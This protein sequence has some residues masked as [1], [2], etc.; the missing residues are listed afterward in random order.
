MTKRYSPPLATKFI[1][2]RISKGILPR[3]RLEQLIEQL[4][5]ATITVLKAPPGFGKSTLA[6]I[7]SDLVQAKGARVAWM[8]LDEADDTPERLLLNV[9]IAIQRGIDGC[10]E[11]T[12][13]KHLSLVPK[14]HM[15]TLL[16]NQVERRDEQCFLF[17]DD[18]HCVFDETLVEAFDG[19]IRHAPENL[20]LVFCGRSDLPTALAAHT[21]GDAL[22]E[23]GAGDLRFTPEE[24]RDLALKAGLDNLGPTELMELHNA[25]EG[26][27]AA[28]RANLLN[29][30]QRPEDSPRL[31][32]NITGLLNELISSLSYDFAEKL[33]RLAAVDKF[34]A[35]LADH[36]T[37][38]NQGFSLIAELERLQLF[39]TGLDRKGEWFSLHPIFREHLRSH[40]QPGELDNIRKRAASWLAEQKLWTDAVR[41][42]LS[43]GDTDSARTWIANCA[44]DV[45]EQG[46][47]MILLDWERELQGRLLQ[48]PPELKLAQA[49]AAA[50]AMR[51]ERA[52]Q[53]LKEAFTELDTMKNNEGKPSLYWECQ[54]VKALT[55]ATEDLFDASGK[56]AAECLPHLVNRHWVYNTLLN[57]I[58]FSHLQNR[59]WVEFYS[60]PPIIKEPLE[61]GRFLFNQVYRLC[62]MGLSEMQQGNIH[63][64]LSVFE[65]A[66]SLAKERSGYHPFLR[67]LPSAFL[68]TLHY[69]QGRL[70]EAFR[71]AFEHID[72]VQVSGFL[73]CVASLLITTSRLSSQNPQH[74]R[75]RGLIEEG[76]RLAHARNWP[77]LQMHLLLERTRVSLLD[78]RTSEAQA[79]TKQLQTLLDQCQADEPASA[80]EYSYA[81]CQASLWCEA[82]GLVSH[83]DLDQVEVMISKARKNNLKIL[84]L[85]L[86]ASVAQ[87]HWQRDQHEAAS[88]KLLRAIELVDFSGTHQILR[89]H[90]KRDNLVKIATHTLR[91]FEPSLQQQV[92]LEQLIDELSN[93]SDTSDSLLA[94]IALTNKERQVLELVALGK[95]NKEI[96]KLLGVGPET[97]KSHMKNIFVKLQVD[98][99]AQAAVIAKAAGVI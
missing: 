99:R 67:A 45:V 10:E 43:A 17:V 53:L 15:L 70:D 2:P 57:V 25:T 58:S 87:I 26:W 84:E 66:L 9:A 59:R 97:V 47:F 82:S 27:V 69:Q 78:G 8:T 1:A 36:L 65:E 90:P 35:A 37:E 63:V 54:A 62:L 24:V 13:P 64:A 4:A 6:S 71:K 30:R 32:K 29:L 75:A 5:E 93:F 76:E 83:V 23:V 96:A 61:P 31:A 72:I 21:Y 50:L 40:I 80:Y 41:T 49:W 3:P 94:T 20:H 34:N 42:A 92:M 38:D 22:F 85:N 52:H 11:M 98:S 55:L 89:D 46:D 88:S 51:A 95:S 74:H 12:L 18:Y 91:A 56:L 79:C 81:A 48:C 14:Q 73:D 77:R 68:A 16:L 28:L 33:T 44:M 60:M 86:T 39:I 19:L 7:W